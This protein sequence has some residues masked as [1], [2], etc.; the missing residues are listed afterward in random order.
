M[1]LNKPHTG[2]FTEVQNMRCFRVIVS[3]HLTKM[4]CYVKCNSVVTCILII[5]LRM[6]ELQLM[7]ADYIIII[8]LSIQGAINYVQK[9]KSDISI[10]NP[11]LNKLFS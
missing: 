9:V 5:L 10:H 6:V 7:M 8:S 3:S 1:K 11:I 2:I 4:I